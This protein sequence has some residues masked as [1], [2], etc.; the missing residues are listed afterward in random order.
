M[1]LTCDYDR[2]LGRV[3]QT[4]PAGVAGYAEQT[5]FTVVSFT[6]DDHVLLHEHDHGVR[7]R[8]PLAGLLAG[9]AAGTLIEAPIAPRVHAGNTPVFLMKSRG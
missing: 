7:L 5:T 1:A 6:N 9:I 3:Y 8:A 2:Y 4:L